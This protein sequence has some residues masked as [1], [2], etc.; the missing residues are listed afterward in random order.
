MLKFINSLGNEASGKLN[1]K[2][3][4]SMFRVPLMLKI[5]N[6]SINQINVKNFLTNLN[7][8]NKNLNN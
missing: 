7:N 5:W 1:R 4:E 2:L 3:I 8:K 6:D